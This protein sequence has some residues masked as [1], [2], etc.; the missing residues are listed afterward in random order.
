MLPS[1]AMLRMFT[2]ESASYNCLKALHV[3][4]NCS[5]STAGPNSELLTEG[6]D[7]E[8]LSFRE[9]EIFYCRPFREFVEYKLLDLQIDKPENRNNHECTEQD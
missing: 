2:S 7:N 6:L 9:P 1:A 8:V 3:M 4:V 5:M